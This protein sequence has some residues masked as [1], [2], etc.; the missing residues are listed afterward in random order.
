MLHTFK[1]KSFIKSSKAQGLHCIV[2][3]GGDML[4]FYVLVSRNKGKIEIEKLKTLKGTLEQ[5]EDDLIKDIPLFLSVDGKGVLLKKVFDESAKSPIHQAIPNANEDEFVVQSFKGDEHFIFISLARKDSIDELVDS[6]IRKKY[7]VLGLTLGPFKAARLLNIFDDLPSDLHVGNYFVSADR[8]NNQ[9][10]EFKKVDDPVEDSYTIGGQA[11]S[12]DY[13]LPFYHALSYYI[14]DD[15]KLQYPSVVLQSEEFTSRRLFVIAGWA[16]L[17]FIFIVL[18]GNMLMYSNY[19]QKEKNLETQVTGGKELL[20]TVSR[21]KEDLAWKEQFLN[22]A[23]IFK[24]TRMS[25]YA[26]QIASSLPEAI[27][28]EKMEIH[29][30]ASKIKKQ[31]EIELQPDKIL[32]DGFANGSQLVNDWIDNLK[33]LGWIEDVSVINYSN[34]NEATAGV[35]SLEIKIRN[36]IRK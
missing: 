21:L 16:A 27:T 7:Q 30:L 8:V 11:L 6:F 12:S 36:E 29:P 19:S 1:D 22:Q 18:M 32:I 35:F 2:S 3:N 28:L 20:S 25:Y 33:K 26:D 13:L 14:H 31:K 10:L 5:M 4:F 24:N 23:G 17:I 34:D 9:I 15:E